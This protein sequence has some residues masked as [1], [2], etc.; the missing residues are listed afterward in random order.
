LLAGDLVG[1]LVEKLPDASSRAWSRTG[2]PLRDLDKELTLTANLGVVRADFK[3][4]A[5]RSRGAIP[6]DRRERLLRT[7]GDFARSRRSGLLIT[8]DEAHV[9]SRRTAPSSSAEQVPPARIAASAS[10]DPLDGVLPT[11]KCYF[12]PSAIWS[13]ASFPV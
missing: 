7:A 10:R 3:L 4:T 13:Q 8:V 5:P 11:A 1:S 6:A 12:L 9:I 2:R